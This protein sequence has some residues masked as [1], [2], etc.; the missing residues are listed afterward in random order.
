MKLLRD[1]EGGLWS[2]N[3]Q[4]LCLSF[5]RLFSCR[6]FLQPWATVQVELEGFVY[7][8]RILK[9]L[10]SA[11]RSS[12]NCTAGDLAIS[13]TLAVRVRTDSAAHAWKLHFPSN[14]WMELCV[15]GM[16]WQPAALGLLNPKC[17]VHKHQFW[18]GLLQL[19][20]KFQDFLW[21][22]FSKAFSFSKALAF[23][24]VL[25]P[26]KKSLK[27]FRFFFPLNI[28]SIHLP[29]SHMRFSNAKHLCIVIYCVS[30]WVW[31]KM[32]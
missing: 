6:L 20:Q 24:S 5:H 17:F 14:Y 15:H 8:S 11:L 31:N 22:K 4:G 19:S 30:T 7:F 13:S 1:L 2:E 21:T 32:S 3:P 29:N 16:L 27:S 9:H 23:T 12:F 28:Q 10:Q 18:I 25:W 26:W